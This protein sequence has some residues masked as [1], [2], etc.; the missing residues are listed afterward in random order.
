MLAIGISTRRRIRVLFRHIGARI[1]FWSGAVVVGLVAV[2]FAELSEW[3]QNLFQSGLVEHPWLPFV[4]A[5]LAGFIVA[6]VMRQY[7]PGSNG[8]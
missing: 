1:I 7:F 4:T 2:L 8:S 5:P 6:W 3:A